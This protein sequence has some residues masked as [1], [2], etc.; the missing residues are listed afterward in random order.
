MTRALFA[1]ALAAALALALA[2]CASTPAE[3]PVVDLPAD[4]VA[5]SREAERTLDALHA[6]AAAADEGRYFGLFAADGVFLGTDA[7]ERW[8]VD[9]FRAYAKPH[10][11]AGR[12]WTYTV[13]RRHVDLDPAAGYA[14][15]H[16]ELDNARLGRCRGTGVLR[17]EGDAWKVVLYDLTI[18]I[19]N[20]LAVEVAEKIREHEAGA[21][22]A[23]D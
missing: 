20:A 21:A 5:L 2:G 1:E 11:D 4:P 12:G 18:P 13:A 17:R 22:P 8:T 23:G 9:E 16:E 14:W 3:D 7:G 15:F 6:A 19:P 10:F